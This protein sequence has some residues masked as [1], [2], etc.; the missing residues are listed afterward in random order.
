[1]CHRHHAWAPEGTRI[2]A[3]GGL[4]T[5]QSYGIDAGAYYSGHLTAA[6]LKGDEVWFLQ[7]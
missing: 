2:Y 3:I 1:M 4:E 6:V 5:L 7:T